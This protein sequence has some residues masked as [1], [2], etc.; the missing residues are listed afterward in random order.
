MA[1]QHII[2]NVLRWFDAYETTTVSM[3]VANRRWNS[4]TTKSRKE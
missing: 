1:L 3:A 2:S 4:E